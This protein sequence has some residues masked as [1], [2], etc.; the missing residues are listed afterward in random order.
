MNEEEKRKKRPMLITTKGW[1]SYLLK[2]IAEAIV[3][4]LEK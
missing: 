3:N 2:L 4:N 1:K